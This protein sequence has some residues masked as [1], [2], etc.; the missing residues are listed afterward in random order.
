MG[1]CGLQGAF[2]AIPSAHITR[3]IAGNPA[4]TPTTAT[5]TIL[6]KSFILEEE[7]TTESPTSGRSAR[8][9]LNLIEGGVS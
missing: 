3:T 2:A 7:R 1:Q 9:Q 6:Q 4:R 5:A 8:S